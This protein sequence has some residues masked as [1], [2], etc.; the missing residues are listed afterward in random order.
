[1]VSLAKYTVRHWKNIA[2]ELKAV[3]SDKFDP[4]QDGQVTGLFSQALGNEP[5]QVLTAADWL[6]LLQEVRGKARLEL[7]LNVLEELA[8]NA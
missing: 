6:V 4:I 7:P 8:R 1:M 5:V 2:E 3:D